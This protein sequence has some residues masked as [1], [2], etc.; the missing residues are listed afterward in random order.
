MPDAML[1][2]QSSGGFLVACSFA[3]PYS[4]TFIGIVKSKLKTFPKFV[5]RHDSRYN[6]M[7]RLPQNHPSE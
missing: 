2:S 7:L 4:I 5:A 3:F 1:G 6:T